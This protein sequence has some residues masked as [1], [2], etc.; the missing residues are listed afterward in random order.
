M[1]VAL[2]KLLGR[3]MARMTIHLEHEMVL[4]YGGLAKQPRVYKLRHEHKQ[5]LQRYI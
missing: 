3:R 5:A 1:M 4:K 2:R